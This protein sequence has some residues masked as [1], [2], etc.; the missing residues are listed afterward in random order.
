[1]HLVG[2]QSSGSHVAY[3]NFEFATTGLYLA[4]TSPVIDH[5]IASNNTYGFHI[6]Y[7]SS[8]MTHITASQ[9]ETGIYLEDGSSPTITDSTIA[10]N[11][12]YGIY[13]YQ[14]GSSLSNPVVH[15]S[16]IYNNTNYNLKF[17]YYGG[18]PN[19]ALDFGENWWGTPNLFSI[20][21]KIYDQQDI[22]NY[23]YIDYLPFLDSED[24]NIVPGNF[25]DGRIS[26][27]TTWQRAFYCY[28]QSHR[29]VRC[30][31]DD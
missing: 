16:G 24:G 3:S 26:Q 17:G 10:N 11:T 27:N 7:S 22:S 23:P 13:L 5:V 6:R 19:V 12:Q 29:S 20:N 2:A 14:S 1:V 4:I 30:N 15:R 28:Q 21:N 18:V 31:I 25:V 9:N 8:T